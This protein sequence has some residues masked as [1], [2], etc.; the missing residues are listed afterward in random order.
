MMSPIR[1]RTAIRH[2]NVPKRQLLSSPQQVFFRQKHTFPRPTPPALNRRV[3]LQ[4]PLHLQSR[5]PTKTLLTLLVLGGIAYYF[6]DVIEVLDDHWTHHVPRTEPTSMPVQF[7]QNREQ[8]QHWLDAHV[9]DFVATAKNPELQDVARSVFASQ[10]ASGW[11]MTEEEAEE[12][13]MPV[14][15]GA[16]VMSNSPCEDEFV[17]SAAPGPGSEQW[18][19]WGVFDGHAGRATSEWLQWTLVPHVSRDLSALQASS[20]PMAITN[21]IM[22]AFTRLDSDMMTRAKHA[23]SWYPAASAVAISALNPALSG[24]CALLACFDPRASKLRV[25]CVGDSRAVL[26]RWDSSTQSYTCIPLSVDQ[27]GFN[28]SEVR[29]LNEEHPDEPEI[30]DPKSGRLLGIAVTRAFGDH[31]WKWDN[32]LIASIRAKF[33]GSHPR[34]GSKTPPYM[35]AEPVITETDIIRGRAE[36]G[37]EDT[38]PDFMIMASD[39]LWDKISST[40]AVDLISRYITAR[41]NGSIQP[42]PSFSSTSSPLTP[43]SHSPTT[44]YP[45]LTYNIAEDQP[46]GWRAEPQYFAIEDENAAVCLIKNALG[47]SRKGLFMGV[48]SVEAPRRRAVYDDTTVIV[49][50]FNQVGDGKGKDGVKTGAKGGRWWKFWGG[51]EVGGS[52]GKGG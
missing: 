19:F 14:T 4:P 36:E 5:V 15:H 31:R 26:G 44:P 16:R 17:I 47:G 6:I 7:Y 30:I 29:K 42:L 46:V 18:N 25:A 20:S 34:P 22:Q 1:W 2:F 35:T 10:I 9:P 12:A 50:F 3:S 37:D 8:V 51:G 23:A 11:M 24:S 43:R 45:G 40:D 21:A 13:Q 52:F 32:E 48:L 33:W 38:K 41:T 39:G 27:T 28:E 49:V